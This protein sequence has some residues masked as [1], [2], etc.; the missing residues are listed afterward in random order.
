MPLI[1]P[2]L[3]IPYIPSTNRKKTSLMTI[4]MSIGEEE[5]KTIMGPKGAGRVISGQSGFSGKGLYR[6]AY[7]Y[8]PVSFA[9]GYD[10]SDTIAKFPQP[11]A[12][13]FRIFTG[14]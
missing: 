12:S 3:I 8:E 5:N 11:D 6:I 2:A 1:C 9:R 13:A 7:T 10:I 14:N 4:A